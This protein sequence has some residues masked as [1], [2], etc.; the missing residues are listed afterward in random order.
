MIPKKM[1]HYNEFVYTLTSDE[2]RMLKVKKSALKRLARA[3]AVETV[4]SEL[5]L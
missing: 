3:K 1:E 5:N 2:Q 4:E